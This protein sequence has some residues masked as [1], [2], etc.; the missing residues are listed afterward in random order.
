MVTIKYCYGIGYKCSTDHFINFAGIRKYAGPFSY[1]LCD[2]ET[3]FYF[4]DNKF[5]N[6]LKAIKVTNLNFTFNHKKWLHKYV[7]FNH[8]FLPPHD[9]MEILNIKRICCWNHHNL[10]DIKIIDKLQNRIKHFLN[11]LESKK[12][13]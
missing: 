13:V 10:D 8:E 5:N 4:I 2:L 3:A 9:R 1:M 6:F 12:K 11:F 7:F